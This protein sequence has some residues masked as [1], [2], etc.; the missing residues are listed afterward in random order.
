MIRDAVAVVT[1]RMA[2]RS[3]QEGLL[4]RD[5]AEYPADALREAI[6]NAV[7]HRDYSMP[8]TEIQIRLFSDRLEIQSPGQSL[9]PIEELDTAS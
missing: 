8:G 7:A 2:Q 4:H 9:V 6:V 1:G 3:V 5:I